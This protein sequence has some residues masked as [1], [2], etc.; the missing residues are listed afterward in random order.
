M[1]YFG[2]IF[3]RSGFPL[4]ICLLRQIYHYGNLQYSSVNNTSGLLPMHEQ[5]VFM[6]NIFITRQNISCSITRD[7][8]IKRE[9]VSGLSFSRLCPGYSVFRAV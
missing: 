1:Q 7:C 2:A 3:L 5:F 6:V 4:E 8:I 9:Y